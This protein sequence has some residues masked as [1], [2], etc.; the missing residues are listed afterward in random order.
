LLLAT[1][2]GFVVL[3]VWGCADPPSVATT[4]ITS[5]MN[6]TNAHDRSLAALRANPL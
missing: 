2:L 4:T 6:P 3:A 1:G 5:A